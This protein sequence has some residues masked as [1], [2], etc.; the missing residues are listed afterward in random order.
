MKV[1]IF[2]SLF[3]FL[4]GCQSDKKKEEK[5]SEN[6]EQ[7]TNEEAK[8]EAT[9]TANQTQTTHIFINDSPFILAINETTKSN[10]ED[11]AI[12]EKGGCSPITTKQDKVYLFK[13]RRIL[14][15]VPIG[16]LDLSDDKNYHIVKGNSISNVASTTRYNP[17]CPEN[18][19]T[20]GEAINGG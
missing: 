10:I 6:K 3:F 17:S 13:H 5:P 1:F 20:D 16:T 12:I 19:E 9:K 7:R 2:L 14:R 4:L 15:D 8:E 11:L 18:K